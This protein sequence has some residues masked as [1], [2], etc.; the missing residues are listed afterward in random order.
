MHL[1]W[2]IEMFAYLTDLIA[3]AG[4]N[5]SRQRDSVLGLVVD[6]VLHH[7]PELGSSQEMQRFLT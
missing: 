1:E 2:N 7:A 5:G 3:L 6:E 4:C